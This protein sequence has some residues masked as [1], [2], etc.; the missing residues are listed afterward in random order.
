MKQITLSLGERTHEVSPHLFGLF[1]EDI[2]FSCDGGLN[3]NMVSNFSFDGIYFKKNFNMIKSAVLRMR[4]KLVEDRLRYWETEKLKLQSSSEQPASDKNPW[5]ARVNVDGSGKLI[6][7]GYGPTCGEKDAMY[8]ASG[9]IYEFSCYMKNIDFAGKI[10]VYFASWDN[11]KLTDE[12]E[13]TPTETWSAVS[14]QMNGLASSYGHLVINF[15]GVGTVCLDAVSF[16]DTDTWGAGDP[17]WSGGRFRRDLVET[18]QAMHPSFLRFPGGCIVEGHYLG[19]EYKWKDTVGSVIDRIPNINLWAAGVPDSGYDQSYQIGFYEYFLLCEDLH[20]DPLPVVWA[21]L[22][23]QM[24]TKDRLDVNSMEFDE[25]VVQN[26]LDLIEY[27]TGNPDESKWAKMRAEAGHPNPFPMKMIGIGNENFGEEYRV[28][29]EKV[30]KAVL[31]RY[32][33]MKCVMSSGTKPDDKIFRQTWDYVRAYQPEVIVDEHFYR[34]ESW[35]MDSINRYDHYPRDGARVFLG[36]YAAFDQLSRGLSNTFGSALAESAFL[37]GLERNSDVVELASYAPLFCMAD[38]SQWVHNMIYFNGHSVMCTP[39][40]YTQQMYASNLGTHV[41]RL[42]GKLPDRVYANATEDDRYCYIKLVNCS[43]DALAFCV[44]GTEAELIV[45]HHPDKNAKNT[46]EF[47]GDPQ[48]SV[49]P[50]CKKLE[51][52]SRVIKAEMPSGSFA[53]LIIKKEK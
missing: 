15:E 3:S 5:H 43:E 23:C 21:G 51:G 38:T 22:N 2:N 14:H 4:P 29:F 12:V 17:K 24:R 47:Y 40:F 36:E 25:R 28:R 20:M 16:A 7:R 10:T 44:P 13:I 33:Y 18:L 11:K 48:Y 32:P 49:K 6:N 46:L 19:N 53:V 8:V 26:A 1:L 34:K 30:Q 31:S 45:L 35:V 39:N 37:T 50:V 9:K 42:E 27:A 52:N 41:I